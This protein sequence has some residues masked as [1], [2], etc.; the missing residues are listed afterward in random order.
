MASAA[1]AGTRPTAAHARASAASTS[2]MASSQARPETA[3]AAPPRAKTPAK[4]SSEGKE[5][6]LSRPLE[7]DVERVAAFRRS[8]EQR[9]TPLRGHAGEDGIGRVG[10]LL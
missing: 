8:G 6:S 1:G 9:R 4:R 10:L 2:S 3:A 5:D 7:P